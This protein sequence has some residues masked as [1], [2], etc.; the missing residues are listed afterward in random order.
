ERNKTGKQKNALPTDR[1]IRL[2]NPQNARHN[3]PDGARHHST[4]KSVQNSETFYSSKNLG[5]YAMLLGC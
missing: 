2:I 1:L 3:H 4:T 5:A